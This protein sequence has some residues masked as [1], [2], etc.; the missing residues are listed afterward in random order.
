[1]VTDNRPA[2][3]HTA[4]PGQ[5]AIRAPSAPERLLAG[6]SAP[7]SRW[8]QGIPPAA[9]VAGGATCTSASAAFVKLSETSAGTTAFLRCALAFVVLLPMALLSR[10]DSGRRG[11]RQYAAAAAAGLLLGIDYVYWAASI[12]RVGA[13]VATVLVNIQIL[14]FPLLG[15]IFAAA[16]LTRR[17]LLAVPVMLA[18]IALT[19]GVLAD[20]T[21]TGGSL[22]GVGFGLLAGL[23]YAGYLFLMRLGNTAGSAIVPVC[24]STTAAALASAVLGGLW[25]GVDLTPGWASFGW[26]TALALIG[27]VLAWLLIASALP[28]LPPSTSATILLLHPVLSVFIGYAIGERLAVT[29]LLGCVLVVLAAW[30][31]TRQPAAGRRG[32]TRRWRGPGRPRRAHE[33]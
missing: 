17:Y 3:P 1:M 28:R 26:L 13:G 15:A 32:A 21:P 24:V 2:T 16:T 33:P 27:Q 19:G 14:I 6:G 9:L 7:A 10:G 5:G 4:S 8:Y 12:E 22:P 31:A 11:L 29:Q 18:G 30:Q 20:D 23:A 25:G